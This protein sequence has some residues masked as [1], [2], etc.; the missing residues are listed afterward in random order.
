[1]GVLQQS[2][3]EIV[4]RHEILRTSFATKD[5]Q[6]VQIVKAEPAPVQP[7]NITN[8]VKQP[9]VVVRMPRIKSQKQVVHRDNN[10]DIAYTTT[11]YEYE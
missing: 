10:G 11:V 3:S 5:E 6:P 4:R 9:M 8:D 7:I 2:I 1:M